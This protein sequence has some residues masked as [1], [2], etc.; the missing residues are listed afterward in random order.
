[1]NRRDTLQRIY[2]LLD[3]HFGDLRWWP[4]E[5]PF[6]V[7]VGAILTQN[8]GWANVEKAI[9]RLRERAL[10]SPEAIDRSSAEAL[11]EA[12]RP[13]GYYRLKA[14]RLQAFVH[15]FRTEFSGS[16]A[17][18]RAAPLASLRERLLQVWG[19]GPETADSILLYACGKP[20][21]VSDAYTERIL[22]RHDLLPGKADY[23]SIR[24]LFMRHLPP[25]VPFFRQYHALLVL[26]GKTFCRPKVPLC[27]VCPLGELKV[28]RGGGGMSRGTSGR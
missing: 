7:M 6:E 28:E 13:S 25:D 2:G 19:I 22:R 18:M 17:A 4:A 15:F 20:S 27:D 21:F 12:V 5:D 23:A 10:L 14:A 3:A 1:M 24:D 26:T 9:V 11:A 8:T 16:V